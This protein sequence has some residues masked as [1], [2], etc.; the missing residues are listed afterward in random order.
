MNIR[1]EFVLAAIF[2]FC[3]TAS[4]SNEL[5]PAKDSIASMKIT[6]TAFADGRPIPV[7]YTCDG[8][9][10]S[11]PLQ[12]TNAPTN[13]KSFALIA[14]D[15]DAPGGTW[16]HWVIYDLPPDVN[17]LAENAAKS[18]PDN[19]R[20]GVNDFKQIGYGGPC[21]PPGKP[22]HYH[23]KIYA[24]DTMIDLPPGATKAE[25]LAAMNGH[26]LAR[27]ELIGIYRRK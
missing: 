21:P 1:M 16:V 9:N 11:P 12:W 8:L 27:G 10:I 26:V 23:F 22:H 7:Q 19:A 24:L 3:L 15:P 4:C 20:Q 2:G 13:T 25:L 5:K 6:S 18:P 14:D 17:A